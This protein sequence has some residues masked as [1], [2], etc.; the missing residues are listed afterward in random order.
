[1]LNKLNDKG[2]I[3][4]VSGIFIALL[5]ATF[6]MDA[7]KKEKVDKRINNDEIIKMI[8]DASKNYE[9]EISEK[10]DK[11]N[12]KYIYSTDGITEL[13][14]NVTLNKAYLKYNNQYYIVNEETLG[15]EKISNI[16]FISYKIYDLKELLNDLNNCKFK[17]KSSTSV[18]CNK[19]NLYV[20]YYT[21]SLRKITIDDSYDI[22][23]NSVNKNDYNYILEG[24]K[25]I[26]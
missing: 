23:V 18:K 22:T 5:I 14:E 19:D 7:S 26:Y 25:L 3:I 8:S 16:D 10:T 24:Y 4:I 2:K 1:M 11:G 12:N 15:I 21:P 17:Y 20:I 9:I 6:T 13:F